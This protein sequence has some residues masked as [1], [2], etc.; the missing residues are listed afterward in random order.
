DGGSESSTR[1]DQFHGFSSFKEGGGIQGAYYF[2]DNW[3]LRG[4][5]RYVPAKFQVDVRQNFT[6]VLSMQY[7]FALKSKHYQLPFGIV[8]RLPLSDGQKSFKI[9]LDVTADV[10]SFNVEFE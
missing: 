10:R 2:N 3:G 5:F 1:K 6:S 9:F 4:G 7:F 8:Y